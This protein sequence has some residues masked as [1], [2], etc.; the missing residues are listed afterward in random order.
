VSLVEDAFEL[1]QPSPPGSR[2]GEQGGRR[3]RGLRRKLLLGHAQGVRR[4]ELEKSAPDGVFGSDSHAEG[5][6]RSI[7]HRATSTPTS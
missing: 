6:A 2:S 4:H 7:M 5:L 1:L 3:L